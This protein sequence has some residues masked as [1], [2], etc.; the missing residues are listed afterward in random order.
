MDSW[1]QSEPGPCQ[2][3]WYFSRS[4][5]PPFECHAKGFACHL[6]DGALNF[7]CSV[8]EFWVLTMT[9]ERVQKWTVHFSD[10]CKDV[11]KLLWESSRPSWL[12][13]KDNNP[14]TIV[15]W[16]RLPASIFISSCSAPSQ[17]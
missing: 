3:S 2:R 10:S 6:D 4:C 13:I 15:D 1:T 9:G 8:T 5:Q 12:R 17:W 7:L 11:R 14:R 16:C